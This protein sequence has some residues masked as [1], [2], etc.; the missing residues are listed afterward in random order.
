MRTGR[1][2]MS[3]DLFSYIDIATVKYLASGFFFNQNDSYIEQNT[4]FV[5]HSNV[6]I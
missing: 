5:L 1:I 2:K 3:I 4:F 6:D